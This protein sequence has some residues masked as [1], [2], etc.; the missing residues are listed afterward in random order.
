MIRISG[1]SIK[2]TA[3]EMAIEKIDGVYIAKTFRFE[4]F[5]AI[6]A[7]LVFAW[8]YYNNEV[9][10]LFLS[11]VALI[12]SVIFHKTIMLTLSI[13]NNGNKYLVCSQAYFTHG[14]ELI[15]VRK[16]LGYAIEL[17]PSHEFRQDYD[18]QDAV[19]RGHEI[20]E[21]ASMRFESNHYASS[22]WSNIPLITII[23][24][25][26]SIII[27]IVVNLLARTSAFNT[28]SN[29]SETSQMTSIASSQPQELLTNPVSP[30]QNTAPTSTRRVETA[31]SP[32]WLIGLWA[33]SSCSNDRDGVRIRISKKSSDLLSLPTEYGHSDID[34]VIT[35]QLNGINYV[36]L[37]FKNDSYVKYTTNG[38]DTLIG[39]E[40]YEQGRMIKTN[41]PPF[42]RCH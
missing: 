36:T 23:I 12:S 22:L 25:I 9:L 26:M 16:A 38:T 11:S 20:R 37:M 13:E 33:T 39:D 42:R 4:M 21:N 3:F 15:K 18:D 5:I 31:T 7:T 40:V 29:H 35:E 14:G 41:N 32:N 1:I 34:K 24:A 19:V 8:I 2:T 27:I 30:L 6:V 10:V 28:S 17:A